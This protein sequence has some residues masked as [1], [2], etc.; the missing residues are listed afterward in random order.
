MQDEKI[1]TYR[2]LFR[3]RD[4]VFARRWEKGEKSGYSPE[5]SF[6]W[7]EF[8]AHRAQGGNLKTFENKKLVSLSD[9]VIR[10]H[11]SGQM[12]VGIYPILEGNTTYFLVADFDKTVWLEECKQYQD[13]MTKLGLASYIERSRSGNGGHVW[14]F[15]AEAYPCHKSRSIGLEAVRKVLKLSEFDKE[16][17]F[18]RLFPNQDSIGKD[19]LGNLIALPF[20]G[21]SVKNGN[22][23]FIDPKNSQPYEDQYAVL[24]SLKCH[25]TADLDDAYEKSTN[26]EVIG[27]ILAKNNKLQ[28]KVGQNITLEKRQLNGATVGFLKDHLNFLN[29]EY[30]TKK[31]FGKSLYQTQK[32]FRLIDEDVKNVSLPRGFL[33]RLLKFL[34]EQDIKY[35]ISFSTPNLPNCKIKS[36]IKLTDI[37]NKIVEDSIREKQG[38]IVSP[39]GSGKTMMGMELIA[40]HNK[41]A[42]VLVHR[43][44]LLDQWI[45]RIQ[46]YLNIPKAH[47]GR[48]ASGKKTVG[49]EVTVGLLQ[50]FARL[51]DMSDLHDKFGTIIVD[52][53][54]HIPAKTFR[55]VI[56]HLNPEYLYGLTATPTRKHN[57]E[58]LI[59]VYIG[60]VIANMA[61]YT[62]QNT[63]EPTKFAI[64][65][66]ETTLN[67]PFN[68][69]TDHPDLISK[70]ICYDTARNKLVTKDIIEQVSKSRKTL[71]LSERK[72]HL[73]ILELYL[74]GKCEVLTL[75]GDDSA[76]SRISKQKQV[77]DGHYQVL[78]ATGQLLGEG[79][80]IENIESLILAFPFSFEGKLTQYIGRLLHSIEPKELIDY[81]DK[82]IPYLDRQFKN[83][84]RIYKKL[85]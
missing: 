20:Q 57:D 68:W 36:C 66:R 38:V 72:E 6:D 25:S 45:D 78:L 8:N 71:V 9:E 21:L 31:R 29:T 61:D 34:H 58:E 23:I 51:K 30:L 26:G 40:R 48:Y 42:L 52:E 37:Q 24:T 15:F 10:K 3:G 64:T 69:K 59:Y 60:D 77:E 49:K 7:T 50:S 16:V 39:P 55:Q 11:L 22:T 62:E 46:T 67:M 84:N 75:T 82:L 4:D 1:A 76:A 74:K 33:S 79:V 14:V 27:K 35:E 41:P 65:I 19:G 32:Y 47:I 17:S 56:S 73:K 53:C 28:V 54:H 13:E 81:R 63:N 5:Y 18:D 44:Q 70:T 43:Q 83:R 80:H 2:Q 85:E 12:V